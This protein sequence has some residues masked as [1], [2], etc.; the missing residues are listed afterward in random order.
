MEH[1]IG[2][3]LSEPR[4]HLVLLGAFAAI[5]PMLAAVGVYGVISYS[6]ARRTHEIGVRIALGYLRW[7]H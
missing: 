1:A 2:E 4:F 6:A 7:W 5:A 3:H